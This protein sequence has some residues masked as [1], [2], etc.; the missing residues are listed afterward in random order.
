M[1]GFA[2]KKFVDGIVQGNKGKKQQDKTGNP[3]AKPDDAVARGGKS[4]VEQI[5][6]NIK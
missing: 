1:N 2:N 6:D 5:E 3:T 4:I